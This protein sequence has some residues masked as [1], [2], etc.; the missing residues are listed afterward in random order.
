MMAR[1]SQRVALAGAIALVAQLGVEGQPAR[2]NVS[3]QRL[4]NSAKE[5]QNWLMYGGNYDNNRHTALA[6]ITPDNVSALEIKWMYQG[7]VMGAWESTPLVVDG[8][9][10]VTQ[11][12]N[13]VIAIDAR[14]GTVFWVYQWKTDPGY[15]ACCG[16]NNKGLAI[17]G[18]TLF[19]GTLD[20]SVVAIDARSGK[21]LWSTSIAEFKSGYSITHAPL[22]VKDK[23]IV[24]VGGGDLGIRGF[25]T[26]LDAKTGKEVWRFNTIPGPGEPGHET[27]SGETWKNGGG[28]VWVTGA[29]DPDTNLTYWGI[30]N[31]WPDYN[32]PLRPGDSLFADSVVGLD[33]DTGQLKWHFQF[34][35]GDAYDWDSVQVPVLINTTWLGASRKLMLWGNRNGFFY[36]L[37]RGTGQFLLGRP[38]IKVNWAKE[39]LNRST[40]RPTHTRQPPG[41]A[42]FPG[43][44]G[45]TNWYSPSYSPRTKLAYYSI[46]EGY[47]AFFTD[48]SQTTAV[49]VPGAP[50]MPLLGRPPVNNW[51]DAVGHGAIT[52]ID[53]ISGIRKWTYDMTDVTEA[54]ILTTGTDVLFAGNREGYFQALDARTGKLLWHRQLGGAIASGPISYMAGGKQYVSVISGMSLVTLGLR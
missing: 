53:P 10:Y 19:M 51:T 54:G 45:G 26:A 36:V 6:E 8:I 40:G 9:M 20:A 32:Q 47:S 41:S 46:W 49:P 28:S 42:T 25:I 16:A 7:A 21:P 34:T 5:A 30:G 38:F 48:Q 44:M 52:A 4:L 1:Y 50:T 18:D 11:R 23:V 43:P 13:D 15:R 27:W 31:P 29:Y 17:L 35:P 3:Y 33:A 37:D 2:P 24:G 12:P 22:I 14:T 39:E